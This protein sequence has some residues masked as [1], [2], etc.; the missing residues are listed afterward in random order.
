MSFTACQDRFT[1]F[2]QS[3]SSRWEKRSRISEGN[4]LH[5]HLQTEKMSHVTRKPVFG[6]SEQVRLKP[7]WSGTEASYSL[8]ILAISRL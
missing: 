6:V 3:K 8:E 4:Q 7:A 5:G 1:H 2:E